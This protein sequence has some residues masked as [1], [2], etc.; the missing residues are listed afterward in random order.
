MK[1][2]VVR[3]MLCGSIVLG[4]SVYLKFIPFY[5]I[6]NVVIFFYKNPQNLFKGAISSFGVMCK[7]IADS[8]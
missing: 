3:P 6:L 7:A 4:F 8:I 1:L 5:K 2:V